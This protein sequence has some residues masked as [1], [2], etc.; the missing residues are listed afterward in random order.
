M[1]TVEPFSFLVQPES[2]Q[3]FTQSMDAGKEMRDMAAAIFTILGETPVTAMGMNRY[4]HFKMPS[5][6]EWHSFGHKL[7]PKEL[8]GGLL[9]E[10]KTNSVQVQGNRPGTPASSCLNVKV[11]PSKK[12][13]PGVYVEF[14]EHHS[15][16]SDEEDRPIE[17]LVRV[18]LSEWDELQSFSRTSG[19]ALISKCLGT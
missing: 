9:E 1:F 4:M 8:W 12:V 2:F 18:L 3:V 5:E 6:S 14:N 10:P 13:Q 11:E 19:E 7:V 17:S 16:R 15:L